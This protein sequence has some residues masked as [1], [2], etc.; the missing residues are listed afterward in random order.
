MK[1]LRKLNNQMFVKACFAALLLTVNCSLLTVDCFAQVGQHYNS[2]LYSP[3]TY[4]DRRATE[5]KGLP[6]ALTEVGIEQNLD[7][8]LPLD[9]VFVDENGKE[10]QLNQYFGKKPVVIVLVY[11]ECPMLCNEVLNGLVRSLK[12]LNQ[13]VGK[14][15]D[16]VAIS[17]DAREKSEV[18]KAK[19]ETYVANYGR[20]SSKDGWHFLTGSQESI[21]KIT[22]TVGFKYQWDETTKQF[23]HAGGVQV[24]TP[25]GKLARYFY[26]IEYA[27]K[28][29][30]FGLIEASKY[31]IGSAVEQLVLYCFHYD[32]STGRYGFV[33]MRA[34]R[35]AGI[36]TVV[37]LAALIFILWR[38]RGSGRTVKSETI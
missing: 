19:K 20:E 29:I 21:D 14:E 32:P 2:P 25:D 35:L 16:V 8:Q 38:F 27:P 11:Y 30:Q 31:K 15:F 1:F 24:A 26:G 12:P 4:E 34:M 36:F 18:A 6:P 10:V 17:F 33:I 5:A 37:G 7:A 9:T 28:E 13:T 23:A 3:K 22:Q